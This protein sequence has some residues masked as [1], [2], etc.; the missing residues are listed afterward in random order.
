MHTIIKDLN[1]FLKII[2]ID[3]KKPAEIMRISIKS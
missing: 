3:N 1:Y 2:K